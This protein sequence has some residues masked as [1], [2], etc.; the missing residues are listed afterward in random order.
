MYVIHLGIVGALIFSYRFVV[1]I[2]APTTFKLEGEVSSFRELTGRSGRQQKE[3]GRL[4]GDQK[5]ILSE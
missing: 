1:K 3:V 4:L 2:R 5:E